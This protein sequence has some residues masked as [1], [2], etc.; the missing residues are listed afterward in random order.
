MFGLG[1]FK[2]ASSVKAPKKAFRLKIVLW[3]DVR[4]GAFFFLSFRESERNI[5]KS[6]TFNVNNANLT[7]NNR[8]HEMCRPSL[9]SLTN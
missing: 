2:R 8:R 5:K 1:E 4:P 6:Y 7:E 3:L 9:P